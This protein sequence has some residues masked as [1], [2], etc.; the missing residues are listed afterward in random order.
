MDEPNFP[1]L[2]K[3]KIGFG[4]YRQLNIQTIYTGTSD[5]PHQLF[6]SWFEKLLQYETTPDNFKCLNLQDLLVFLEAVDG[7]SIGRQSMQ[8]LVE[9][10]FDKLVANNT[11]RYYPNNKGVGINLEDESILIDHYTQY[12]YEESCGF[13]KDLFASNLQKPM[14]EADCSLLKFSFVKNYII[15]SYDEEIDLSLCGIRIE[16]IVNN[17]VE[18]YF[19]KTQWFL[20]SINPALFDLH[21]IQPTYN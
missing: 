15:V 1:K 16:T 14:T 10:R 5:I 9:T 21:T 6:Q 12:G 2:S 3:S 8:K 4:I 17:V 20:D 19:N 18:K 13:N 7:K 11:Y